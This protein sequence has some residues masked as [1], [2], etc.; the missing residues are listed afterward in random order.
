MCLLAYAGIGGLL[1]LR[2]QEFC[3]NGA[4]SGAPSLASFGG[5]VAIAGLLAGFIC[6]R[7]AKP[8]NRGHS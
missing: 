3:G 1:G 2:S 4:D 5:A 6:R 7:S 8:E